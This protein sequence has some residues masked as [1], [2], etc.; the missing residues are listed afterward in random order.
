M[1][2]IASAAAPCLGWACL[3]DGR[4]QVTGGGRVEGGWMVGGW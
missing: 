2:R 4:W 3:A 1:P